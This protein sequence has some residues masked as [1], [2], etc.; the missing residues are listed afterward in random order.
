MGEVVELELVLVLE[1]GLEVEVVVAL[2]E[3]EAE[4]E[5]GWLKLVVQK[6]EMAVY[7]NPVEAVAVLVEASFPRSVNFKPALTLSNITSIYCHIMFTRNKVMEKSQISRI[8][9]SSSIGK[10]CPIL[11]IRLCVSNHIISISKEADCI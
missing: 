4:V 2:V 3:A 9:F 7:T 1:L 11:Q 5:A 10:T 8:R 6:G